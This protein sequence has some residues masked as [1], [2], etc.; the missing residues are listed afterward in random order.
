MKVY[1]QDPTIYRRHFGGNLPGF[2]GARV[3]Y[4]NGIGSFLGILARKAIPLLRAGVKL[5]APHAK[6]AAKAIAKD[7]SNQVIKKATEKM[8]G[9][10]YKPR[11][12]K[13][14]ARKRRATKRVTRR[15]IF[16]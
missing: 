5:A 14:K 9:R 1:R 15:N 11:Q 16:S 7:I 13:P 4:A 8:S 10:A 2:K 12:S 6:Q 3:Q